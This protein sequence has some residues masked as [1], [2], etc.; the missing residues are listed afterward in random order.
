MSMKNPL[1]PAGIEPATFLFVAQH[2]NHCAT[3][4]PLII[5]VS[6]TTAGHRNENVDTMLYVPKQTVP[7]STWVSTV[8]FPFKDVSLPELRKIC[9]VSSPLCLSGPAPLW[10]V[11]ALPLVCRVPHRASNYINEPRSSGRPRAPCG[12]RS[13]AIV[14]TWCPTR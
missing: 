12:P 2:L 3:A 13:T 9:A 1:T 11:I 5:C 14:T 4:V 6:R 7:R 8:T 10:Y